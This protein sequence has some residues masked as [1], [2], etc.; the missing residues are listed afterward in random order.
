MRVV[1]YKSGTKEFQLSD[2]MN[3]LN[4]QMFIY[5]FTLCRSDSELAGIESG[6]LYMHSAR[7]LFSLDR[8]SA[9]NKLNNEEDKL[10]K[11]KG[12]VLNDEEH[13]IAKHMEHDLAGRFI[14]ASYVKSKKY[15]RGNIAS[16]EELGRLSK[17]VDRLI[18]EMGVSLHN[19]RITQNPINGKNHDKTCEF[20]DYRD[21]CKNRIEIQKREML[22]LSNEEVFF[23]LKE[24]FDAKVD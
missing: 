8:H 15:F 21:V 9:D 11:M 13:E 20:C 18:E 24:E 10:Y 12:I 2:I 1:D 3:G 23:Q 7:K 4:L 16:L 14:P 19:G 22:T 17:K 6:V 5:L